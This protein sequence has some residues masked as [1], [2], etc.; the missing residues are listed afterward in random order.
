MIITILRQEYYLELAKAQPTSAFLFSD[1]GSL[2][3]A[4]LQST[5]ICNGLGSAVTF[6]EV[7]L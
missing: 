7:E 6:E 2:E 4:L 3:Y 1:D 5:F